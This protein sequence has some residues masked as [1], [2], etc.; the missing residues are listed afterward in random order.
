M[1]TQLL[2]EF[3]H[4]QDLLFLESSIG[5]RGDGCRRSA[6]LAARC[7]RHE[8]WSCACARCAV[9]HGYADGTAKTDCHGYTSGYTQSD[10]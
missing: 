5:A 7:C 6:H 2:V 8:R 9:G 1:Q 4:E 10:R 3:R